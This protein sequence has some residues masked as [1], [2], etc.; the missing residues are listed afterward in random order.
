VQE[1]YRTYC[2][3]VE[4]LIT[5]KKKGEAALAAPP[6]QAPPIGAAP[7]D[8]GLPGAAAPMPPA[9]TAIPGGLAG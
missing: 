9:L 8:A 4:G 5:K 6:M 2:D 7:M 1:R 3:L